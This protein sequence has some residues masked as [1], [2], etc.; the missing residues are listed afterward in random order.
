MGKKITRVIDVTEMGRAGGKAAAANRS[1]EERQQVGRT[2][3]AARWKA[4]YKAHPEKLKAK[5]EREARKRRR[6]AK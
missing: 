1:P 2:A 3:A 5:Q 4:Y 6:S